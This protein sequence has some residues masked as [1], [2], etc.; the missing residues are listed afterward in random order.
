MDEV[1]KLCRVLDPFCHELHHY[2]QNAVLFVLNRI[3]LS[4][5]FQQ[6]VERASLVHLKNSHEFLVGHCKIFIP[7]NFFVSLSSTS[8]DFPF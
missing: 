5:W 3:Y 4:E 8:N 1:S 6:S 7:R 2:L